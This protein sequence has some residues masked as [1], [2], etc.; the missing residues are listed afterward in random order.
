MT[1]KRDVEAFLR[2]FQEKLKVFDIVFEGRQKNIDA[3]LEL[4]I[5]ATER[6]DHIVSLKSENYFRGPTKDTLNPGRADYWEFGKTI[7]GRTVYIK[8]SMGYTNKPVICISFHL[9]EFSIWHP[10]Q[11]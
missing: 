5:S 8:I 11:S 3:L 9:A 10:F 2:D 7:K 4:E 6:L 1:E